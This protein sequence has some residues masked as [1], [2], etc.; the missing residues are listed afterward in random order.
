MDNV[1]DR[2]NQT[3][4]EGA[5]IEARSAA[6]N[7]EGDEGRDGDAGNAVA[8]EILR[9]NIVIAEQIKLEEGWQRPNDN[10]SEQCQIPSR[11]AA[12][13]ATLGMCDRGQIFHRI[14]FC[15]L[16]GV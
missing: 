12:L 10:S 2:R 4:D 9:P 11:N 14:E 1:W 16:T 15:W 3:K 5:K 6:P 8:I 13:G 7:S